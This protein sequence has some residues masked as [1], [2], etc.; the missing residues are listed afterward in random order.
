MRHKDPKLMDEI[1]TYVEE[2]VRETGKSPTIR[3]ISEHV[4][5][6]R[7]A[8]YNYL[9]AMD[10][11]GRIE[12]DGK[13]ILTPKTRGILLGER[14]VGILG[15]AP[16]GPSNET[17]TAFDEYINLPVFMAGEGEVFVLYAKDNSMTGAGILPGD[18]V[19]VRRQES[20]SPGDIVAAWV[21]GLGNTLKRFR[22][23]GKFIILHPEN[24]TMEDIRVKES[25]CRIQGV[26]VTVFR[27]LQ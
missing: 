16:C 13:K 5:L 25:E 4:P 21:D 19:I 14:P 1:Q 20:A 17:G 7:S 23:E 12:Y 15:D 6:R 8:V 22:R 18:M 24:E 26:A 3:E 11:A 27:T 9:V 2:Y 10:R